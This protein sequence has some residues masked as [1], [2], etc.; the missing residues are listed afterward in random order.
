ML[1]SDHATKWEGCRE[2]N[3]SL[4]GNLIMPSLV[5]QWLRLSAST[6]GSVGSILGW[7]TRN[8]S[9]CTEAEAVASLRNHPALGELL[10]GSLSAGSHSSDGFSKRAGEGWRRPEDSLSG[11]SGTPQKAPLTFSELSPT[12]RA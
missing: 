3:L 2:K 1:P 5:I 10:K 7:R 9:S 12:S 4:S 6:T 11:V 8:P